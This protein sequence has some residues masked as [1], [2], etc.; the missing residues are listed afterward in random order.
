MELK[1]RILTTQFDFTPEIVHENCRYI[2]EN[3]HKELI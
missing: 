1:L 2:S 3:A